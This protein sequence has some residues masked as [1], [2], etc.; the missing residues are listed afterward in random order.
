MGVEKGK[1][2]GFLSLLPVNIPNCHFDVDQNCHFDVEL[3]NGALNENFM[4]AWETHLHPGF[5]ISRLYFFTFAGG[6]FKHAGQVLNCGLCQFRRTYI[7]RSGAF[8]LR[9]ESYLKLRSSCVTLHA[10]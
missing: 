2:Y 9:Y 5:G 4:R 10:A 7:F 1:K 6:C 8:K 3:S